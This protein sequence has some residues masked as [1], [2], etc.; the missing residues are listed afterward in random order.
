M[1]TDLRIPLSAPDIV[2]ADLCQHPI[3]QVRLL[4]MQ[5]AAVFLDVFE[6]RQQRVVIVAHA[7]GIV[8]DDFLQFGAFIKNRNSLIDF[9]LAFTE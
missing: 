4:P 3:E 1:N 9:L 7:F 8:P 2:E 5:I 6:V